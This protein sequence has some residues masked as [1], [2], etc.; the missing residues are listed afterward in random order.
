LRHRDQAFRPSGRFCVQCVQRVDGFTTAVAAWLQLSVGAK[1]LCDPGDGQD[2]ANSVRKGGFKMTQKTIFNSPGLMRA[3]VCTPLP[4]HM[5]RL[6][7]PD[8]I[9]YV[10]AC[11][12]ATLN[13]EAMIDS[14]FRGAAIAT[15]RRC[16]KARRLL[17]IHPDTQKFCACGMPWE[18]DCDQFG[19]WS[20]GAAE[21]YDGFT[22]INN[23][24][25]S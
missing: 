20:C 9:A 8:W 10:H 22:D 11:V 4:L 18:S 25:P 2:V 1:F 3:M 21:S 14:R 15:G 7:S 23:T 12:D 19:C 17:G 13:T 16:A 24:L 6:Q 5:I